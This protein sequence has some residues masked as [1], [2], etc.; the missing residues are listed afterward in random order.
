MRRPILPGAV[1]ADRFEIETIAEIGGMGT[2]FRAKDG[3]S[4]EPAALKFMRSTGATAQE[5]DRFAREAQV[6]SD[7]KHPG[8]VTIS[9]MAT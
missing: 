5:K 9:R 3:A 6:L 8:I 2:V 1:I 7:L 4:G